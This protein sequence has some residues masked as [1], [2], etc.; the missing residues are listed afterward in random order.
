[1]MLKQIKLNELYHKYGY[2]SK[3]GINNSTTNAKVL[4]HI[5]PNDLH[6]RP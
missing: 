2:T 6:L 3:H 4:Q 1:M 5:V